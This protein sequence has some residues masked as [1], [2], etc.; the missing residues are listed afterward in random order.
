[1][2]TNTKVQSFKKSLIVETAQ[3]LFS[4]N[5]F[6]TVTVDDIA[7]S[8]GFGKSTVYSFFTSKEDILDTVIKTGFEQLSEEFHKIS[9][10]DMDTVEALK[11]LIPLQYEFFLKFNSLIFSYFQKCKSG[12]IKME[13]LDEIRQLVALKSAH[14]SHLMQRGIREG[15]FLFSDPDYLSWFVTS[16]IKGICMPSLLRKTEIRDKQKDIMMLQ[17]AILEGIL[18]RER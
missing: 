3:T 10:A 13:R 11:L 18:V 9:E 5:S 4:Q 7:K 16:L 1:M 6:E 8:A 15:V 2:T 12:A 17:Q 14:F